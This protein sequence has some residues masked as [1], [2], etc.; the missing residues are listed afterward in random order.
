[1][2]ACQYK[3]SKNKTKNSITPV[4]PNTTQVKQFK[5]TTFELWT[6][7][8][9]GQVKIPCPCAR[10]SDADNKILMGVFLDQ[11]AEG[12][13]T[14][15][16]RQKEKAIIEAAKALEGSELKSGRAPKSI[17][18]IWDHWDQVCNILTVASILLIIMLLAQG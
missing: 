17:S 14:D 5:K 10:Y 15:N 3:S 6:A 12:N 7:I 16:S 18:S 9:P 13:N 4:S 8:T 11:K 2:T 1:M